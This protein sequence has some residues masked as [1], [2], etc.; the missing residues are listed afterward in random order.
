MIKRPKFFL[1][2]LFPQNGP[3][4]RQKAVFTALSSFFGEKP[5][6]S[7]FSE[8]DKKTHYFF[9]G[10]H[11]SSKCFCETWKAVLATPPKIF[12]QKNEV[13]LFK[14]RACFQ[15]WTI[16]IK[17]FFAWEWTI[18]R[19]EASF[20][21]SNGIFMAGGQKLF[22]QYPKRLKNLT[23]FFR[24]RFFFF[25]T[26]WWKHRMQLWKPLRKCLKKIKKN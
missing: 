5:K 11:F 26:F 13:L 17:N 9:A 1:K 20:D 22:T 3:M 21:R 19:V 24:K 16:F 14:V 23:I 15:N 8:T 25:E 6:I 10:K 2:N 18:G 7:W 4:G 12:Q